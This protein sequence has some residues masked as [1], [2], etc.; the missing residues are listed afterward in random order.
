MLTFRRL[1][2]VLSAVAALAIGSPAL[3]QSSAPP[4]AAAS[5]GSLGVSFVPQEH[6][7]GLG[8]F[9]QIGFA[10][11]TA[12]D[13]GTNGQF[14]G[15]QGSLSG[16]LLGVGFGGNKS[17]FVGF[18]ADVNFMRRSG[19]LVFGELTT[20]YLNIPV[21]L[22]L[23]FMGHETKEAATAYALI[24]GALDLLLQAKLAGADVAEQFQRVAPGI[25]FGAGF[26]AMRFGAEVRFTFSVRSLKEDGGGIFANLQD[27]RQLT[28]VILFRYR[29]R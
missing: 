13:V 25:L 27:F 11:G 3:A 9:P 22:R 19:D 23:N 1:T 29:L 10:K 28:M 21:Y 4:S 24:G 18:G 14:F 12:F 7:Q 5:I 17:S 8:I 20:S 6:E 2:T 26:E 15:Q 16:V